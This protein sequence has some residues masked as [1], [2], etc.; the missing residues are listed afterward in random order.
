MAGM[1]SGYDLLQGPLF[2]LTTNASLVDTLLNQSK[3]MADSLS[4]AF[5]SSI[6]IPANNLYITNHTTDRSTTNGLADFETLCLEWQYSSDLTGDPS[7]GDLAQKAEAYLLSPLKAFNEP[8]PGL[9]S[10]N[11]NISNGAFW[12]ATGGWNSGDHS[13]Y[14][15]LITIGFSA[16]SD[17]LSKLCRQFVRA[18][19]VLRRRELFL[20]RLVVGRQD[21]IDFG[22]A[23]VNG[24]H[25][26]YNSTLTGIGP[27]TFSWNTTRVNPSNEAFYNTNA[28]YITNPLYDLRPQVM[29][30]FYYGYRITGTII[31]AVTVI[32]DVNAANGESF[33]NVHE[34]VLF[35]EVMKYSYLI[36]APDSVFQVAGKDYTNQFVFKTEAHPLKVVGPP[37]QNETASL[38]S[39]DAQRSEPTS[40]HRAVPLNRPEPSPTAGLDEIDLA[41]SDDEADNESS[42]MGDHLNHHVPATGASTENLEKTIDAEESPSR[43]S[44]NPS[45]EHPS[46]SDFAFKGTLKGNPKIASTLEKN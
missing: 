10:T 5:N 35:A 37:D 33:D 14:E 12:D 8:F 46:G 7:Y 1:L 21:Y 43:P 36:H 44:I 11:V 27:E 32:S 38:K 28:F 34:S 40:S 23:L 9:V 6:G 24:C 15:Y 16:K 30:I 2:N 20:G 22:L 4:F 26:L 18:F 3:S 45:E 42:E 25:S 13:F 17:I 31:I 41:K 29:E 39:A 19:D